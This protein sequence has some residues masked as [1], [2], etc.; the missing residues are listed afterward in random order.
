MA[1]E[2][3]EITPE[4]QD[5][6]GYPALTAE[7][8]QGIFGQNTAQALRDRSRRHPLRPGRRPA[9]DQRSRDCVSA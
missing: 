4:F 6:Y 8:K 5:A 9:V 3:F 2:A 7:V 1:L